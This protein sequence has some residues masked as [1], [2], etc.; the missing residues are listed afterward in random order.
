M[1]FEKIA[2]IGLGNMGLPMAKNLHK[3]GFK[4][5]AFDL[6]PKS[7]ES[8]S[9]DGGLTAKSATE[10]VSGADLVITMLPATAHV[11]SLYIGA[12]KL[13]SHIKKNALCVDCSTIAPE[14]SKKLAIEA[15]NLG[16]R[17]IDAPVSGGVGGATAGTLTFIVGGDKSDFDAA[18][19]VLEKM[20]KNLFH[21]GAHGLGQA[22]KI[23]NNMLLAIHMIGTAEA[24][25]LGTKLG[26]DAKVLSDMM[27]VSSG[28]NWSLELYNP[29]PGVMENVPSSRG[30]T[31]GFGADLMKKDL[32][33]AMEAALST[34]AAIPS[35][36]L[37]Y[38]LY[39]LHSQSG[40]GGLDFSSIYEMI[41]GKTNG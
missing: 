26:L 30:Y 5:Q 19:P 16:L 21:V 22:A 28:R 36:S 34:K 40:K 20:G 25:S 13:F 15:K 12:G 17:M 37:A 2:F 1:S 29:H 10:C 41:A 18:K 32:S 8:F 9:Q 4:V 38:E 35:G 24:L 27:K 31:G 11:E 23:C 7:L 3:A 14:M 6:N 39:T 33:L